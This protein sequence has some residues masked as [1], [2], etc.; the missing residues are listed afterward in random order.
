MMWAKWM[1][2]G[3]VV[4]AGVSFAGSAWA[5]EVDSDGDGLSDAWE[6][7][8]GRYELVAW[9]NGWKAAKADAEARG[10]HLATITSEAEWLEVIQRFGTNLVHCWLGGTDE[11]E[12][13]VWKWVTG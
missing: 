7:G 13:G 8:E 5:Q 3:V 12:E 1:L 10:G 11:E 4:A 6:R 9:T 2:A